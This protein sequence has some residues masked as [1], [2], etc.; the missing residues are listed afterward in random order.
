VLSSTIYE[1]RSLAALLRLSH[2]CERERNV[3][4]GDE[5]G[6]KHDDLSETDFPPKRESN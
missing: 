3:T 2:A 4:K 5:K 6:R 1:R